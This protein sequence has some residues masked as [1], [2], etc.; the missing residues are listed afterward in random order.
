[1]KKVMT[2]IKRGLSILLAVAMVATMAP[3]ASSSAYAAELPVNEAAQEVVS[4]E[5]EAAE[6]TAGTEEAS[7]TES[8]EETGEQT[9][10]EASA[11]EPA[12]ESGA[13]EEAGA[14]EEDGSAPGEDTTV[15]G[16]TVLTSEVLEEEEQAT[17]S[18]TEKIG[19]SG[20]EA[21][22]GLGAAIAYVD[23]CV[24]DGSIAA[25][26][27]LVFTVTPADGYEVA[28]V[29]Y[30]VGEED[31]GTL[32]ANEETEQ[33]T[34]AS[35]KITGNVTLTVT[36]K[37][38]EYTVAF[39]LSNAAVTV[40]GVSDAKAVESS[41]TTVTV[42]YTEK[43]SFAFTVA[44]ADGYESAV[45]MAKETGAEGDGT[46]LDP[47]EEGKYTYTITADTTITVTASA[48]PTYTVTLTTDSHVFAHA[49]A[50]S[51]NDSGY[52]YTV[53]K[54]GEI[55]SLSDIQRD[56][57]ATFAVKADN[58]YVVG[59]VALSAETEG[60]ANISKIENAGVE[61]Y[62]VYTIW[63]IQGNVEVV[64]TSEVDT[65]S[66]NSLTLTVS[67]NSAAKAALTAIVNYDEIIAQYMVA[68]EPAYTAEDSYY[69]G[70]LEV[71]A[72]YQI[73]TAALIYKDANGDEISGDTSRKDLL[74]GTGGTVTSVTIS[75]SDLTF[76]GDSEI[77]KI[78]L[79]VAVSAAGLT[80]NEGEEST[81]FI[82]NNKADHMAYSVTETSQVKKV[83]GTKNT[84]SVSANTLDVDF[85]VTATGNYEPVVTVA[86]AEE[87]AGTGF[88]W[89]S[90]NTVKSVTT[91]QYSIPASLLTTGTDG[92]ITINEQLEQETLTVSYNGSEV[93]VS[94]KLN[95]K[96]LEADT[97]D[98]DGTNDTN[99][100]T[101][102]E[103]SSLVLVVTPKEN[104]QI[105]GATTQLDGAA[106][107]KAS[108][109][110]T[111]GEITV[112]M[113]GDTN[114]VISSKGLYTFTLKA[115]GDS[116]T[117]VKNV[118]SVLYGEE[119]I[120]EATYGTETAVEMSKVE[121]LNGKKAAATDAEIKEGYAYATITP[122]PTEAG[123][124]LT[125]NLYTKEGEGDNATEVKIGSFTLSVSAVIKGVTVKGVKK[126]V[127]SQT[128]DTTAEY[129][130]T[131]SPKGVDT[132]TLVVVVEKADDD[133]SEGENDVTAKIE[134]G[135]LVVTTGAATAE[136]I[137]NY[138][139]T[140]KDTLQGTEESG[141][142]VCTFT[143]QPSDP[144]W[145]NAKKG[146]SV[147]LADATDTN[148][149]LTLSSDKNIPT[150]N[151]GKVWYQ[152]EVTS[153]D[154]GVT[155]YG[156]EGQ[157]KTVY[158]ERAGASQTADIQV[159]EN[160]EELTANK[161][162]LKVTLV[163]TTNSEEPTGADDTDILYTGAKTTELTKNV[164]TKASAYATKLTLKKGTTTLY[165]GQSDVVVATYS[166]DKNATCR[167]ID[168]ID[169]VV[170]G[171]TDYVTFRAEDGK[172]YATVTEAARDDNA[173][174]KN[175]PVTVKAK[176]AE[177]GNAAAATLKITLAETVNYVSAVASTTTLY[178]A[179]KK[180][181]TLKVT[182]GS[183]TFYD[184]TYGY[185]GTLKNKKYTYEIVDTEGKGL[186]ESS[187]EQFKYLASKVTVKNG[188]VTVA[189]DYVVS[190]TET[191][192]QFRVKVTA[193][194]YQGNTAYACTETVTISAEALQ[195]G[196]VVIAKVNA[197]GTYTVIT[198][199]NETV[200]GRDLVNDGDGE[201]Y[202]A[203]VIVLPKGTLEKD[204]YTAG[205][206]MSLSDVTLKSSN[207]AVSLYKYLG[208][209]SN[210]TNWY[211]SVSK[212]VSNVKITA[213]A[214][215]GG[216]KSAVLEG[217]NIIN[218][219]Y[220]EYDVNAFAYSGQNSSSIS[221]G[222]VNAGGDW[223]EA[224]T[225]EFDGTSNSYVC[226][227]LNV[228]DTADGGWTLPG[229]ELVGCSF[230]VKGAKV[231]YNYG[232]SLGILP[233]AAT[234]TVTLTIGS[235]KT[236]VK[237]T[238][239]IKNKG[240]GK[241]AAPNTKLSGS[242]SRSAE[243]TQTVTATVTTSKNY[244]DLTDKYV[245][246]E[247]DVSAYYG[248]NYESYLALYNAINSGL[249]ATQ[250]KV[251]DDGSATFQLSFNENIKNVPAGSYT[252]YV[253]YGTYASYTFS[254]DSKATKLTLKVT[255]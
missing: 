19:T 234:C 95:G 87:E 137:G 9:A 8:A 228:K 156:T 45:V 254:A 140:I 71:G 213:T 242:V 113:T 233:T 37:E 171:E 41:E 152:V 236:A 50:V 67:G 106:A 169:S 120:V 209:M 216:K 212:A 60:N 207:K 176:A 155:I 238:Y 151:T 204:T 170:N 107:K 115:D 122:S 201:D 20:S 99:F 21:E 141:V 105:T 249:G 172:I 135:K 185:Y 92:E 217:L 159:K 16:Y 22:D 175:Y 251:N 128:V 237:Q 80:L 1:M 157:T 98:S 195:P 190:Q 2:E 31:S 224:R 252:L 81:K 218:D 186:N 14:S 188:T 193:A 34:L 178:K 153:L 134:D 27:N 167:E 23:S 148:L 57:S 43:D 109:K 29:A 54:E 51:G 200:E 100:Y 17:Y 49:V 70:S 53:D 33:Y 82:F 124:K 241:T 142:A 48:I 91:Y 90:K 78:E 46:E 59:A 118:Y 136:A 32:T 130:I 76:G 162:S 173:T 247:L 198:R 119:Y 73:T 56:K 68:G 64:I 125:V 177:D 163:Q 154:E 104:C 79:V 244:T 24:S 199:G 42:K 3:Q 160:R 208:G 66:A 44:C 69:S 231:L 250:L 18:V 123:K 144:A 75:Q 112:K 183:Y 10:E 63:D 101:V 5:T 35:G 243:G 116:L 192:N 168:S 225:F 202:E 187:S 83:A 96:A 133:E 111:G 6:E 102:D 86:G 181:A 7:E 184:E 227:D 239:T 221:L 219:V 121:V 223:G 38:I 12:E 158:F 117:P 164:A 74:E 129:A 55:E 146:P 126:D 88:V 47:D 179:D 194:D 232:T 85:T 165:Y 4:G 30:A 114:A 147:K 230:S 139:I 52:T 110:A 235:G 11:D 94:A 150:P 222:Y 196:E 131:T 253:T 72:G 138:T 15:A 93:D 132:S 28:S 210:T 182:A 248:K 203:C 108:V 205:E 39:A 61:G 246:V 174:A 206:I 97:I 189:K 89:E 161:Y 13:A 191:D 149:T 26:T 240:I 197:S 215:D 36:V 220:A 180:A 58:K 143:L 40:S 211:L 62:D 229:S 166:F 127:L 103:G 145:V 25:S 226:L 84:Y 245:M 255:K 65:V 77:Q 214:N